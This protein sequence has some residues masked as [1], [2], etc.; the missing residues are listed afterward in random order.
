M[1]NIKINFSEIV[2]TPAFIYS[3]NALLSAFSNFN[4]NFYGLCIDQIFPLKSHS[5]SSALVLIAKYVDGF[6]VSSLFE[7]KLTREFIGEKKRVHF[8]SPGLRED[9]I[10]ELLGLCDSFSFNS[11]SQWERYKDK[12]IGCVG[13]ALRINPQ[14]SF[15]KDRRYDPCRTHSRLGAP[16][17]QIQETL[18]TDPAVF[19]GI[20]GLHFHTNCD[21]VDWE[22]LLKTVE[23]LDK[24]IPELL[25]QCQWINLGGGYLFDGNIDFT[26]FEDAVFLLQNK[27]GLQVIIEPGA[28]IV[29][30]ACNLVSSV[31][32]IIPSD[33]KQIAV[34]DTTVNHM[35]E[36]FEY[37]FSPDILNENED[38]EYSY[39][40]EG[41]TCLAGDHFGEYAFDTPLEIGSKIIFTGMGAYTMV[42]AHM[43]NGI[44]L[45]SVYALT[46]SG[47][48]LLQKEFTYEDFRNRCGVTANNESL[49][50]TI[51]LKNYR[52]KHRVA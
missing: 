2:Q 32:D 8:T 24:Q 21:S 28:A 36:V 6:C 31:I 33:G 11:L 43:F 50:N 19:K 48:L 51:K 7:A 35:P 29:R 46:E 15:V 39:I 49:R 30:D 5:F 52:Q 1:N 17:N 14:L 47:N 26:P 3:E 22:P 18:D 42:K 27:Y 34:L 45:P 16:L 12:A 13:C 10:D 44:N 41:S 20:E 25:R 37:Q 38:G 4:K 23:H 40:L 9:E